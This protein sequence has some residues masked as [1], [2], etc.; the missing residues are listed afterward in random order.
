M[1]D[2][3][4]RWPGWW[5]VSWTKGREAYKVVRSKTSLRY[6]GAWN[7]CRLHSSITSPLSDGWMDGWKEGLR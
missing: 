2:S 1:D 4:D 5:M 3:T 6:I 7:Y